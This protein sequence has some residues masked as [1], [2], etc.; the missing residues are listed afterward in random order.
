MKPKAAARPVGEQP[1]GSP[2]AEEEKR[3]EM[4]VQPAKA[5]DRQA[6][7]HNAF[8]VPTL[9]AALPA[10]RLQIGGDG[11]RIT[12][13]VNAAVCP[14][15][16]V[17]TLWAADSCI[18]PLRVRSALLLLQDVRHKLEMA[19]VRNPAQS[20]TQR[21]RMP[22]EAALARPLNCSP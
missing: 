8:T 10:G 5:Q 17:T 2:V 16:T 6:A 11:N 9:C 3:Q 13:G 7:V 18:Q 12:W 14:S 20:K 1:Q 19:T 4:K 21:T 22:I 15:P